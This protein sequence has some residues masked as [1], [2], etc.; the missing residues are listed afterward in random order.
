MIELLQPIVNRIAEVFGEEIP[1]Y[2]DK[3]NQGVITPCF[4]VRISESELVRQMDNFYFLNNLVTVVYMND[5]DDMYELE[6]IKFLMLTGLREIKTEKG[7]HGL[8]LKAHVRGSDIVFNADYN[9]WIEAE[10]IPDPLMLTLKQ[11][12]KVGGNE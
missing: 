11:V 12:Q 5:T 8:N 10:K 3:K 9:L 7:V 1:I 2:T 6:R 4:F